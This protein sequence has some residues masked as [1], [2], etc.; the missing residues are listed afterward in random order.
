MNQI[1]YRDLTV[2]LVIVDDR[3]NL[4]DYRK[5]VRNTLHKDLSCTGDIQDMQYRAP[6]SSIILRPL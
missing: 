4:K 5:I 6:I 2:V 1:R 3:S